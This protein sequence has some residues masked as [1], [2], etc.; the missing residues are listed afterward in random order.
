MSTDLFE[1]AIKLAKRG[2]PVFPC[3][4]GKKAPATANGLNDATVDMEKILYWWSKVPTCNIGVPTG[5]GPGFVVL[6]IDGDEGYESLRALETEYG[7]LPRTLS[8]RTPSGGQHYYFQTPAAGLRNSAGKV[9]R[10]I[11][12]RGDGGYVLVPP[13]KIRGGA[14]YELDEA[15]AIV[16]MPEWLL[17]ISTRHTRSDAGAQDSSEWLEI[18]NGVQE[19]GRNHA[20]ARLAGHLLRR[21]VDF[22]LTREMLH[23]V[24]RAKFKPALPDFEVDR[25]VES[26]YTREL[27]RREA[28]K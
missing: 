3:M 11:D 22:E 7:A 26:V 4:P 10:H 23:L 16:E 28:N 24:N 1:G 6:D 20:M 2:W 9:G 12:V 14:V 27:Q 21:Y 5:A 19:G 8:V 18:I 13:S 17:E 15:S 25:T